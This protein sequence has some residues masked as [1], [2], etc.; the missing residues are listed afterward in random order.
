MGTKLISKAHCLE[1]GWQLTHRPQIAEECI[2]EHLS[3]GCPGPMILF[4]EKRQETE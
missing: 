4:V 2:E 1:C 3:Q